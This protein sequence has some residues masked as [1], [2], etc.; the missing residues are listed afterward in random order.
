MFVVAGGG[1]GP[2]RSVSISP[3][4]PNQNDAYRIGTLRP[5]HYIRLHVGDDALTAQVMML[6]KG[7]TKFTVG[8]SF[9]LGLYGGEPIARS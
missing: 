3:D 8:D 7:G 4:R 6:P 5:F 2:R 9:R 1:G